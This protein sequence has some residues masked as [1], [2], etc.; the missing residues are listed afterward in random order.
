MVI[1]LRCNTNN[2]ATTVLHDFVSGCT[3]FGL[4]SR[5]RSDYGGENVDVARYMLD[6]RGNGR[7]TF[8]TG[9]SVH[10]QRI[11]RL[12]RDVSRLSTRKYRVI[13]CAMERETILNHDNKIH[14]MALH[15]VFRPRIQRSLDEFAVSWNHHKIDTEH[16]RSPRQIFIDAVFSSAG[17]AGSDPDL[18][19]PDY[20]A[21][22]SFLDEQD[23]SEVDAVEMDDILADQPDILN[24]LMRDLGD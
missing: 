13:F 9:A 4:P 19:E 12:W 6:V 21:Q 24:L 14:R 5:V 20:G 17:L 7:G 22:N 23:T 11:E 16:N 3:E 10:N 18:V 15:F 1:F 8:L 2:K